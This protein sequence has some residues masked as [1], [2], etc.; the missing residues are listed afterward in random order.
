M[1]YKGTYRPTNPSKY[2]GDATN[3][4]Y[5]SLWERHCFRWLDTNSDVISWSSEEVVVQYY[6]PLDKKM[7]RYFPDLWYKTK[8]GQTFLIEVKPDKETK[9]PTGSK[10]SA[11]YVTESVTYVKNQCKWEAATKFAKDNGWVFDVW[12]EKHLY[13]LGIM[14]KPLPKIKPLK[15]LKVRAKKV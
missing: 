3:I 5:R 11:R 9:V 14:T 15:P 12:T 1:T 6:F 7:H 4:V 2:R 13:A 8:G 10:R